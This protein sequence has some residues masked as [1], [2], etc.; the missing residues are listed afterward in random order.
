MIYMDVLERKI[1]AYPECHTWKKT[2]AWLP[3]TTVSGKRVWFKRI[4][5]QKYYK[6]HPWY[7]QNYKMILQIEYAEF[8]DLLREEIRK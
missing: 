2:F 5:K 3:K 8:F 1:F 4:Y 7:G 6:A